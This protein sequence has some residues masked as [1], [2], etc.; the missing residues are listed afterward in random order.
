MLFYICLMYPNTL[1]LKTKRKEE[2]GQS[3][4]KTKG[5]RRERLNPSREESSKGNEIGGEETLRGIPRPTGNCRPLCFLR[6]LM[7]PVTTPKVLL[8]Q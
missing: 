6:P 3:G 8:T 7:S 4:K 1:W 5:W 2:E